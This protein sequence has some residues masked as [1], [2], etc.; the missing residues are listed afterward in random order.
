MKFN[1]IKTRIGVAFLTLLIAPLVVGLIIALAMHEKI[2]EEGAISRVKSFA[3]TAHHI[4][5]EIEMEM[6]RLAQSYAR[7]KS[8]AI[9][10]PLDMGDKIGRELQRVYRS[11]R[12]DLLTVADTHLRVVA[13]A[14][15]PDAV[16]D[17]LPAK[18]YFERTGTGETVVFLEV[19][20]GPE[21]KAECIPKEHL[22]DAL[23]DENVLS[24][25]AVS[26]IQP[27]VQEP[28]L[29]Y[30]LLRK[31]LAV[32]Q[33]PTRSIANALHVNAALYFQGRRIRVSRSPS[34]DPPLQDPSEDNIRLT[35]VNNEERTESAFRKDGHATVLIPLK[36]YRDEPTAVLMIQAPVTYQIDVRRKTW[37]VIGSIAAI[38]AL[39][40]FLLLKAIDRHVVTPI[41]HLGRTMERF[42]ENPDWRMEISP[43]SN[44]PDEIAML[45]RSFSRMTQALPDVLHRLRQ[46]NE[47]RQQTENALLLM[48]ENMERRIEER[49]ADIIR[50]NEALTAE[51]AER[52]KTEAHYRSALAEKEILL[53]EI[54]HR[55]KNN[56][57]IISSLLDMT[58]NRS[59]D[60]RVI[61]ALTAACNK[62]YAMSLINAQLYE[63]NRFDRIDMQI[64]IQNLTA[65]LRMLSADYRRV[66]Y[67]IHAENFFMSVTHANPVALVLNEIL[68]NCLKH[69]FVEQ[70]EGIIDITLQRDGAYNV[71]TVRDNGRGLPPDLDVKETETL[72]LKLIRNLVSL[73]LKGRLSIRSDQG[74]IVRI[75]FPRAEVVE[76]DIRS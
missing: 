40:V 39:L 20:S 19:L 69:A 50:M 31:L 53:L 68:S 24:L 66:T 76:D 28:P 57:Q 8:I 48:V 29:G 3:Q 47:R 33:I 17:I 63:S 49:T 6:L 73:Q 54:H 15:A 74:T 45:Y 2:L 32:Q 25:T 60:P 67:R 22:P 59:K 10:L 16:G 37:L 75:T 9:L 26:P 34:T 71:L 70:E 46:E 21:L 58:R 65:S 38:T 41:Q 44:P 42:S 27:I 43:L 62:I 14:H 1:S 4:Q 61:E 55:V 51:I 72:G 56:L 18:S 30:V 64:F 5:R 11:D 12:L 7:Q 23:H 35:L 36:D 52:Q 13:R